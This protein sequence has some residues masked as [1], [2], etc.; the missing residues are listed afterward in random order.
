MRG[1]KPYIGTE[2]E[3]EQTQFRP[4]KTDKQYIK[5]N[6]FFGHGDLSKYLIWLLKADLEKRRT[7]RV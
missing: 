1:R 7:E 2:N 3:T 6:D 4:L 5:D